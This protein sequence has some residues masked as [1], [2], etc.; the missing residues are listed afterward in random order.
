MIV[1]RFKSVLFRQT[2]LIYVFKVPPD[3]FDLSL[4]GSILRLS[5][6][7]Q[8]STKFP[9]RNFLQIYDFM[10]EPGMPN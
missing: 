7:L 4:S 8:I 3:S 1:C 9:S 6:R 10:N 2:V 5:Y